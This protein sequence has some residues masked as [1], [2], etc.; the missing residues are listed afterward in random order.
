MADRSFRDPSS[1]AKIVA[2]LLAVQAV[3]VLWLCGSIAFR[4][5]IVHVDALWT[6]ENQLVT[7]DQ[8]AFWITAP[9][10]LWWFSCVHGN[11]VTLGATPRH[12][13]GGFPVFC[14][15]IPVVGLWLP[16][17]VAVDIWRNSAGPP[18]DDP[19]APSREQGQELVLAWWICFMAQRCSGILLAPMRLSSDVDMINAT[20][21]ASNALAFVA[22]VLAILVVLRVTRRQLATW[23]PPPIQF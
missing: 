9:L 19:D 4:T 23:Q 14:W 5:W 20:A 6:L 3:I 7:V 13:A 12:D 17:Q 1:L 16:Y 10:F 2:G 22:A 18:S 15:F 21:V 11:L 8:I